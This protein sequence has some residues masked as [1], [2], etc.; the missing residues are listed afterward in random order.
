M[1]ML[2]CLQSWHEYTGDPR[3]L[4]LMQRYFR[5]ELTIPDERFL[6]PYWQHQRGGDNLGSRPP[7]PRPHRRTVA[8]R[9]RREIDRGT[10]NW[11]AGVPDWHN[12]NMSQA[13]GEPADWAMQSGDAQERAA[14]ERNWQT[15]RRRYGQ[16]PGGM[17]GGDEN[18]RQGF[19]DP[20]QAIETCGMVEM[21]NT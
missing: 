1:V 18:C 7:A 21:S 6:P 17:F 4:E 20:R 8:V 14:A 19:T 5:Y 15:I 10:A 3:V 9:S 16:V 13:F 2:C 12:V 11:T